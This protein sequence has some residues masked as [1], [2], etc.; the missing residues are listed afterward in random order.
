MN[1][2][3]R[4][5]GPASVL[6]GVVWLVIWFHQQRAHGTTQVNEMNVVW[7]MTWMDSSRL[8]VI[9]MALVLVGLLA[10]YQRRTDPGQLS[11]I[12]G[13]VTFGALGLLMVATML[14]FWPFPWGTYEVTFEEAT[15]LAGSNTSGVIQS[16]VSLFFTAG[17]AILMTDLVRAKVVSIWVAAALVVGGLATI[18]LSPVFF[19]PGLA[20]LV[21][22]ITVWSDGD[23]IIA[24]GADSLGA[25]R[26]SP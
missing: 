9:A 12:G 1:A 22:G 20:W 14:E 15:G 17:L 11:K 25:A 8:L 26:T 16:L 13:A 23:R 7:G 2:I 24:G 3:R 5:G 18:F 10:L 6:A 21:L 19:V 4:L